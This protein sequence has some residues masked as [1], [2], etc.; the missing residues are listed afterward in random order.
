M[1]NTI[2]IKNGSGK[3][4]AGVLKNNELGFDTTNKNLYIGTESGPQLIGGFNDLGYIEDIVDYDASTV[5]ELLDMLVKPGKYTFTDENPYQYFVEVREGE[6]INDP[7][8]FQSYWGTQH[9]LSRIL[10]R[11]GD[12]GGNEPYWGNWT[13]LNDGFTD[14]G[15]FD[16]YAEDAM[17]DSQFLIE[18]KYRFTD[19]DGW[20]SFAIVERPLDAVV[21]QIYWT[22]NEGLIEERFFR[23]GH[24][25]NGKWQFAEWDRYATYSAVSKLASRVEALENSGGSG[26]TIQPIV[27][28]SALSSTSTNPVQNRVITN[29]ISEISGTADNAA[30]TAAQA[31]STASAASG[32][33]N[34]ASSKATQALNTANSAASTANSAASKANAALPLKGGT[35]TG[36]LSFSGGDGTSAGKIV[37]S[38]ANASQI[39]DSSAN[40]IF[41]FTST[42]ASALTIGSTSYSLNLRGS[43]SRPTY[44]SNSIALYSDLGTISGK[45]IQ[46][47]PSNDSTIT[48]MNRF[49]SDLF[50]QGDGNAPNIPKIAGFYL[51]KSQSDENR[52]MDIVS[53]SD[54]SYIDF[55]KAGSNEDYDV[56]LI[57]NVDS[58]LTELKWGSKPSKILNVAGVIQQG[59]IA[60]AL[61]TDITNIQDSL[62][63]KQPLGN[64]A[65]QDG[66]NT[67][68]GSNIFSKSNTFDGEQK[69]ANSQYCPTVN[70]TAP[71]VG[72]AF[73]ASRGLFNEALIDKIIM[74][75]HTGGIPFYTYSGANSG[76]FIGLTEVARITPD[77]FILKPASGEGGQIQLE[78]AQNDTT[79]NGICIDTAWGK[80]RIFGL[81]SADEV[82]KK[83]T[84][85]VIEIDPYGKTINGKECTF[86]GSAF[87]SDSTAAAI[88]ICESNEVNF[89]SNIN[90]IYFGYEN[91]LNSSGVVNTYRFGTHTGSGGMTSGTIECGSVVENGTAL[92]SKYAPKYSYGDTPL[93]PGISALASGTLYFVY[94]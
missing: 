6:G 23:K 31:M 33:A 29:K 10:F 17:N 55:N 64:Y 77:A 67:F 4:S 62:A 92:A 89:G 24:Y 49:Q 69:F 88:K 28:D 74:T 11:T 25:L 87:K 54:Y 39:T 57:A 78:A 1:S 53:G 18:G 91:R 8:V 60:V 38:P 81:P 41:G 56:R 5:E 37:L 82:S 71:G 14:L 12:L 86:T 68:S 3:P 20:P 75:A 66:N 90:I 43:S 42:N 40:T 79:N 85:Q 65:I 51:G 72:C 9:G 16:M 13:C 70:D 30:S 94:E 73:K 83:G 36:P 44:N 35:M 26:G 58:G 45:I 15:G 52:H 7:M 76:A 34:T 19:G 84:G 61:S 63:Q 21:Y 50:V 27:V 22:S 93:V 46:G 48:G 47:A 32:Q 2:L 59:G 80:L